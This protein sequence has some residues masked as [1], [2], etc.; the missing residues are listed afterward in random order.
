MEMSLYALVGKRR[1]ELLKSLEMARC[2]VHDCG[3]RYLSEIYQVH[4][5]KY[6]RTVY[7]RSGVIEARRIS[8]VIGDGGVLF[9]VVGMA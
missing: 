1:Q 5:T 7:W 3:Q 2:A 4:K 8:H 9:H 6:W